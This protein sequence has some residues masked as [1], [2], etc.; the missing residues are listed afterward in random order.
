MS[1]AKPNEYDASFEACT[2]TGR[3]III[4]SIRRTEVVLFYN[5]NTVCNQ[6]TLEC[7]ACD[8]IFSVSEI[9]RSNIIL[10]FIA[11]Q[12]SL[13]FELLSS[14]PKLITSLPVWLSSV[15]GMLSSL[16]GI[17]AILARFFPRVNWKL[18][19]RLQREAKRL[20]QI[21]E[22]SPYQEHVKQNESEAKSVSPA[23]DIAYS[24]VRNQIS[25]KICWLL[26]ASET[27]D[28]QTK[29]GNWELLLPNSGIALISSILVTFPAVFVAEMA[30]KPNNDRVILKAYVFTVGWLVFVLLLS[31]LYWWTLRRGFFREEIHQIF[32]GSSNESA[33]EIK[34]CM[35][36]TINKFEIKFGDKGIGIC[37]IIAWIFTIV[38]AIV[39]SCYSYFGTL[40][41]LI[42]SVVSL[43][44]L[45]TTT[46]VY[47]RKQK[48]K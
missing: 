29:K 35:K 41:F 46:I 34:K 38:F 27:N 12:T 32:S 42:P 24:V 13:T 5:N 18:T 47:C 40:V 23:E 16:V 4:L 36:T 20:A 10:E 1:G 9:E 45:I 31:A 15:Q 19:Q 8:A 37:N 11:S 22:I 33:D 26:F 21:D 7:I 30:K 28:M 6:Y 3:V 14:I 25:E 2:R 43:L 39:F 48:K 17:V 44:I